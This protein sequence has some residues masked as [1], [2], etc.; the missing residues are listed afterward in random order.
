MYQDY[1]TQ[2]ISSAIT[3]QAMGGGVQMPQ[4]QPVSTGDKFWDAFNA[5]LPSFAA[6]ADALSTMGMVQGPMVQNQGVPQAQPYV[7]PGLYGLQALI[8][9]ANQGGGYR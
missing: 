6:G 1:L 8:A 9:A 2:A 4:A 3:P 7:G 5:A